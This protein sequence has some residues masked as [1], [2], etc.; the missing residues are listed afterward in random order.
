MEMVHQSTT[1][2]WTIISTTVPGTWYHID[3]RPVFEA[4]CQKSSP[5]SIILLALA[6]FRTA[7][8]H[9]IT[10]PLWPL[11]RHHVL[12]TD[13]NPTACK[14]LA[15]KRTISLSPLTIFARV[16][17]SATESNHSHVMSRLKHNFVS[18]PLMSTPLGGLTLGHVRKLQLMVKP[19]DFS[20]SWQTTKVFVA[21][22]V[23]AETR[24][25]DDTCWKVVLH[26]WKHLLEEK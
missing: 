4:N 16:V 5:L 18:G 14:N 20:S 7:A 6:S 26:R 21:S 1:V 15:W 24:C 2:L 11:P 25:V 10:A 22:R 13:V 8:Y 9:E 23:N 3:N 12:Q 19:M 17:P